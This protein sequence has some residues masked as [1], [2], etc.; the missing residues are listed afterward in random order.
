MAKKK[1]KPA[2]LSDLKDKVSYK[3]I[4]E[5]VMMTPHGVLT[6]KYKHSHTGKEWKN[7][8]VYDFSPNTTKPFKK[9]FEEVKPKKK[10]KD[11][12]KIQKK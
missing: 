10:N 2:Q 5:A 11:G 9:M 8:L 1:E 4:G 12:K 3:Y 7:I 6:K